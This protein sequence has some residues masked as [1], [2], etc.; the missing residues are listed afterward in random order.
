MSL[1]TYLSVCYNNI[2]HFECCCGIS[3]RVR[4]I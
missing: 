1:D 2:A 4:F 3:R